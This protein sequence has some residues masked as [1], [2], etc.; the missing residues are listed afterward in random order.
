[1]VLV[2]LSARGVDVT[3]VELILV[4]ERN[5]V[6]QEVDPAPGRLDRCEHRIDGC[7][8]GHIAIADNDAADL[9]G[10]RLDALLQRV[11]LIGKR[12]LRAM[13]PAG[14]GNAPGKR[15]VVRDPHDQAAFAAHKARVF[16]HLPDLARPLLPRVHLW[17]RPVATSKRTRPK[18]P[19]RRCFRNSPMAGGVVLIEVSGIGSGAVG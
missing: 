10:Q 6:D 19:Q 8:I 1:M 18:V 3:A 11:A 14:L 4:G 12:Q 16:R 2:K 13:P 15:T 5:G 7:R 17:H 9:L